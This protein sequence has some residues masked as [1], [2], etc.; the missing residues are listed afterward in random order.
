VVSSRNFDVNIAH[1]TGLKIIII[2]APSKVLLASPGTFNAARPLHTR[3]STKPKSSSP[4]ESTKTQEII[5][6]HGENAK[7]IQ[8]GW[9]EGREGLRA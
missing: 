5:K 6:A 9:L 8:E 2:D 3:I 7:A 1:H 4:T